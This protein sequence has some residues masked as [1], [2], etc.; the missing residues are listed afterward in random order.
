MTWWK[1]RN[2]ANGGAHYW[3]FFNT[4]LANRVRLTLLINASLQ[5]MLVCNGLF[6]FSLNFELSELE[7]Q[8]PFLFGE[9]FELYV[10]SINLFLMCQIVCGCFKPCGTSSYVIS[11][12]CNK[13][14]RAN[15]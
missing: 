9:F 8:K 12:K 11:W 14:V 13:H 5:G 15:T 6:E 3:F 2:D 10:R 4:D 1:L 7:C